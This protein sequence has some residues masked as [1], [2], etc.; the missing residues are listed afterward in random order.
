MALSEK[1]SVSILE[2]ITSD[3]KMVTTTTVE[4]LNTGQIEPAHRELLE[5]QMFLCV[6]TEV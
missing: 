4:E 5:R 2:E 3:L 1:P 6:F